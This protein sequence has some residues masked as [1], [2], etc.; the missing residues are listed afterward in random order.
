MRSLLPEEMK[1]SFFGIIFAGV[2]FFALIWLTGFRKASPGYSTNSLSCGGS[3]CNVVLIV[4]DTLSARHL[5]LY[6]YP[7]A[8]S[9][10]IDQYFTRGV[11]FKS[12]SSNAPWTLPSFASF[13]T[14]SLPQQIHFENYSDKLA[15]NF[16]TFP[17]V[18][19]KGGV[20]TAG[21]YVGD[22]TSG[23][24]SRFDSRNRQ[25]SQDPFTIAAAED[26]IIRHQSDQKPFF[27]M[28]HNRIV[29][30]PYDPPSPYRS[31]FGAPANYLG[32]VTDA[33]IVQANEKGLTAEE[34]Q[35]FIRQYDQELRYLDDLTKGF[36]ASLP[37]EILKK[38]I[39]IFT[40]DHGE[41]FG[42]HGRYTHANSLY[43]ELLDVP[44]LISGPG[45]TSRVE[46]QPVSLLDLGPTIIDIFGLAH[47]ASFTGQSLLPLLKGG[48]ISEETI[49]SELAYKVWPDVG[50]KTVIPTV[51]TAAL[52]ER[53][54]ISLRRGDWK[55]IQNPDLTLELYN[56]KSDPKE[57]IN[58]MSR[59]AN[60][61]AG[62]LAI[63]DGLIKN[64]TP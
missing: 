3:V 34:Q 48:S 37:E 24:F 9:P 49:R 52:K 29:H 40:S 5:G 36:F 30:D 12:A 7:K 50:L 20:E 18:L 28:L 22:T 41:G 33:Q 32:A 21:F 35:R 25:S 10:F 63:V 2:A 11:V 44:L 58:L 46:S 51:R 60:L 13:F 8:T 15:E 64:L 26:W 17:E 38:T 57:S 47:P 43:G 53:G 1:I 61:T 27:V 62:D 23:I 14:S 55:L 19:R 45:L 4:N 31:L 39:F 54:Y 42:E 16:L 56:L 59:K 6:S